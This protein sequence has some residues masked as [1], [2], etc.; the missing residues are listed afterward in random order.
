M[1]CCVSHEFVRHLSLPKLIRYMLP[2]H[3]VSVIYTRQ[4]VRLL[5]V[6]SVSCPCA[7]SCTPGRPSMQ[8]P[9][10]GPY[11]PESYKIHT[12][13]N[14]CRS[15]CSIHH[16]DL[17]Q[18]ALACG[19]YGLLAYAQQKRQETTKAPL[20]VELVSADGHGIYQRHSRC[21]ISTQH[22]RYSDSEATALFLVRCQ[23]PSL[24]ALK[25]L[26]KFI[27]T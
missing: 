7:R 2:L 21:N 25:S 17:R 9:C 19:M 11:L 22:A 8:C 5:Y 23:E 10:Y 3:L 15:I 12:G 18:V 13:I 1:H 16:K 6:S 24:A 26:C 14:R 20:Q 4:M 27:E